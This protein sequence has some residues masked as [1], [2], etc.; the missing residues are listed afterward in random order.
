MKRLSLFWKV[1]IGF[2]LAL[3]L[4]L[5]VN[6]FFLRSKNPDTRSSLP[7]NSSAF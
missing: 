7:K 6:E 2:L 1:Y 5:V 4:S 3:F